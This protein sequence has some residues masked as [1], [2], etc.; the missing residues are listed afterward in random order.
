MRG[1]LAKIIFRTPKTVEYVKFELINRKITGECIGNYV[2]N[3][4][5]ELKE[6]MKREYELSPYPPSLRDVPLQSHVFMHTFLNPGDHTS[7]N[8]VRQLPKKLGCEPK[9]VSQQQRQQ[10]Q[11][12]QQSQRLPGPPDVPPIGWGIHIIEGPNTAVVSALLGAALCLVTFMVLIWSAS[13]DDIQG[14]TGIGQYL[15]AL[16][17]LGIGTMAGNWRAL[18]ELTWNCRAMEGPDFAGEV[19]VADIPFLTW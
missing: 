14:A 12:S 8:A 5:P 3:S 16:I 6:I 2:K 15:L 11:Q 7:G 17:T 18:K 1:P 19:S 4:I 13:R 9:C 10:P